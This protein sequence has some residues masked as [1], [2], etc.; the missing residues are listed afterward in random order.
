MLYNVKRKA[1][2]KRPRFHLSE[3]PNNI[4][5]IEYNI[6]LKMFFYASPGSGASNRVIGRLS[7]SA[8]IFTRKAADV[9]EAPLRCNFLH[10]L[11]RACLDIAFGTFQSALT[12]KKV[13]RRANVFLEADLKRADANA[14]RGGNIVNG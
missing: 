11:W 2:Y 4:Y 7:E 8:Q 13:R 3:N 5:Y 6:Y 12:Q 9:T 10:R 1:V 14:K